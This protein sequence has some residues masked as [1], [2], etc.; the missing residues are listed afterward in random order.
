MW[1]DRKVDEAKQHM[2]DDHDV[3]QCHDLDQLC[4]QAKLAFELDGYLI[5]KNKIIQIRDST[6]DA[7][8]KRFKDVV[9]EKNQYKE[10]MK[11]M[12]MN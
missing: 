12:Q 6:I 5:Q 2:E 9:S 4:T 8:L 10:I 3:T 7:L 1:N 11:T